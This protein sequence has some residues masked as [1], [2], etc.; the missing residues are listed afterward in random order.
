MNEQ[1]GQSLTLAC[2]T[3]DSPTAAVLHEALI[4]LFPRADVLRV[5]TDAERTLPPT[6]DCAVVDATVHDEDGVEVLRRLRARGYSG[7]AVVLL[8]PTQAGVSEQTETAYRMGARACPLDS[9][10]PDQLGQAVVDALRVTDGGGEDSPSSRAVRALRHNQRLIAAGELAMRL[11]HGLNNPLAALLAE[12][13]LLEME[14]LAPDHRASVKRIIELCRR[15]V[16]VV[17]GLD[18]V[19][20]A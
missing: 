9:A 1:A 13:Q 6:V 12:A 17:R 19:G 8:R 18:G 5:D 15:V 20:R 3:D 7:G 14:Q 2:V 4:G 16:N 11:Q 10:F